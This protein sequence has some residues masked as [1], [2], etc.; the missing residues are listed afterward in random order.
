MTGSSVVFH[1]TLLL[2]FAADLF[3]FHLKIYYGV[4]RDV[5]AP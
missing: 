5:I 2:F 1:S 4:L 3:F